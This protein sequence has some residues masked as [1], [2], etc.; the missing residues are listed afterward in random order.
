MGEAGGAIGGGGS[1]CQ[2]RGLSRR[3][4][5]GFLAEHGRGWRHSGQGRREG[6]WLGSHGGWPRRWPLITWWEGYRGGLKTLVCSL[7]LLYPAC[8]TRGSLL[9]CYLILWLPIERRSATYNLMVGLGAPP[10]PRPPRNPATL[11]D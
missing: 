7:Y 10:K 5:R 6:R 8:A 9:P 11:R 2:Q 4:G 1:S 3:C